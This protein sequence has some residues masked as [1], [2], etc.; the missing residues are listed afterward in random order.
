M[1][2]FCCVILVLTLCLGLLG[3]FYTT[4]VN[5]EKVE[6]FLN[7][8]KIE[9]VRDD[10]SSNTYWLAYDKTN[11]ICYDII[12]PYASSRTIIPHI[13]VKDGVA[14]LSMYKD[15]E[16]IPAPFGVMSGETIKNWFN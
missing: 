9:E 13:N 14:F 1:K 8:V 10:N 6:G 16:I 4:E 3:C 12:N 15:G 7:Y 11:M 2:K 5:G